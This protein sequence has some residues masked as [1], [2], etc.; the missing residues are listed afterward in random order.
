M[1]GDPQDGA[2]AGSEVL[3]A[4]DAYVEANP[5]IDDNDF[6][7]VLKAVYENKWC[8]KETMLM[9]FTRNQGEG[10]PGFTVAKQKAAVFLK[11]LKETVGLQYDDPKVRKVSKEL[12]VF[13]SSKN[14]KP[15]SVEFHAEL[16]VKQTTFVFD[17]KIKLF[18]ALSTLCGGKLNQMKLMHW[19]DHLNEIIVNGENG[20]L[21]GSEVLWV[22]D[23]YIE[24][25]A[26]TANVFPLALQ[27]LLEQKW[28]SQ[29]DVLA[30]YK[31]NQ[32]KGEPGFSL[33]QDKVV[34]FFDWITDGSEPHGRRPRPDNAAR[35]TPGQDK[36]HLDHLGDDCFAACDG[37][38]GKCPTDFC[39]TE[40]WCCRFGVEWDT[41]GCFDV[42][43]HGKHCCTQ[44]GNSRDAASMMV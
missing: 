15:S 23:A 37:V 34:P 2:L 8:T 28:C 19:K 32:G 43:C 26:R 10:Q 13:V 5:S 41:N 44:Q 33:A 3:W 14:G 25:H 11:W 1:G 36:P 21:E 6:S 7:T 30:Y 42:G 4:F 20:P 35:E 17:D 29:E 24:V 40:G 27:M 16:V 38:T 22:F 31:L 9:Y 39:G 18:I 12:K